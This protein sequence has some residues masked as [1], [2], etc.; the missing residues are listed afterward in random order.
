MQSGA[1]G[2]HQGP[3]RLQRKPVYASYAAADAAGA[4]DRSGCKE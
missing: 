3:M 2:F 4:E 1:V